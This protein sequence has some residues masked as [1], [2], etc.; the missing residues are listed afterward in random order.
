LFSADV[1]GTLDA[2]AGIGYREIEFAGL[3]GKTPAEMR[4]LLDQLGLR[5]VSSHNGL[6]DIRGD[7]ERTLE[8]ASALGQRYIVCPSID[9][10]DRSG[11]GLRAV[12]DAFNRA[13]EAASRHGIVFGYHNHDWEFSS[14]DDVLPYDLLLERCDPALVTMQMDLH[15]IV[16]AGVDPMSYIAR[17]PGRF[18]SVHAK[19][20]TADGRMVNVGEGVIDFAAIHA[21]SDEAGIRHWFVEHD[22]PQDPLADVTVS[23]RALSSIGSSRP[24]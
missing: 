11:E 2:V 13:G 17:H 15:W 22:S 10:R 21:A 1:E 23:F 24:L 5:A 9:G 8:G 18:H 3:G 14:E 4:S 19:D 6:A 16:H 7:W 12:A 20:R